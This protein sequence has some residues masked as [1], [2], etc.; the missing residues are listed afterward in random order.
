MRS[1]SSLPE[2]RS[3]VPL[4]GTRCHRS[5]GRVSAERRK[6]DSAALAGSIGTVP[7]PRRFFFFGGEHPS[8]GKI[9]T[10]NPA[11]STAYS[12]GLERTGVYHVVNGNFATHWP[13]IQARAQ[14]K[15]GLGALSYIWNHIGRT[16]GTPSAPNPTLDLNSYAPLGI[17]ENTATDPKEGGTY[18]SAYFGMECSFLADAHGGNLDSTGTDT[19]VNSRLWDPT[20]TLKKGS[21]RGRLLPK[22]EFLGRIGSVEEI[23]TGFVDITLAAGASH[24]ESPGANFTVWIFGIQPAAGVPADPQLTGKFTASAHVTDPG[25]FTI[26]IGGAFTGNAGAIGSGVVCK[27]FFKIL[28]I[29]NPSANLIRLELSQ[30]CD[31]TTC[32][33]IW[34]ADSRGAI[35]LGDVATTAT[36][37]LGRKTV[38]EHSLTFVP[39]IATSTNVSFDEPS[40]TITL[41]TGSWSRTPAAGEKLRVTGS[42]SNNKTVTVVSATASTI[43]C[44][45]DITTEGAGSTVTIHSLHLLEYDHGSA[46]T[47]GGYGGEGFAMIRPHY[48]PVFHA[49]CGGT[50]LHQES[51]TLATAVVANSVAALSALGAGFAGD[52]VGTSD[53]ALVFSI[54]YN[55]SDATGDR[56]TAI[57]NSWSQMLFETLS[58][59]RTDV[60]AAMSTAGLAADALVL[61][62]LPPVWDVAAY[63]YGAI[64]S[65]TETLGTTQAAIISNTRVATQ[66]LTR[67]KLVEWGDL[68][69][70]DAGG[71]T[72]SA[73]TEI[74]TGHRL[75]DSLVSVVSAAPTATES[76]GLPIY[77]LTGQSQTAGNVP[78]LTTLPQPAY[79]S[80]D[81]DYD[82][83]WYDAT[84]TS[85]VRE[86][87]CLIWNELTGTPEEYAPVKNAVTFPARTITNH[88]EIISIISTGPPLGGGVGP[89]ITLVLELRKRHPEG[90]LLVKFAVPSAAL[91]PVEVEGDSLPTFDPAVGDLSADLLGIR[92]RVFAW[93]Y[94]NGRVPDVKAFFFDQGESDSFVGYSSTYQ[95]ALTNFVGWVRENFQTTASRRAA[96]PFV[97]GRVQS[98]AR[99]NS[100][101]LPQ[102]QAV[103]AAQDAVA[104]SMTNVAIAS[105]QDLPIGSDNI[106]RTYHALLIAGQRLNDALDS[107]TLLQDGYEDG[108]GVSINPEIPHGAAASSG[109]SLGAEASGVVAGASASSTSTADLIS[110][111]D[112][113][114]A[115]FLNNGAIQS[116][117]IN[118]RSVSRAS[119]NDLISLRNTLKSD[120]SASL[121]GATTYFRRGTV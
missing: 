74:E 59:L 109:Q 86:R 50:H 120:Y 84:Y 13:T 49:D 11:T 58:E 70:G 60:T 27:P 14:A 96:L 67:A 7:T 23:T 61:L 43:V 15:S 5:E 80:G 56:Q 78:A 54:G 105:M 57:I 95:A 44:S 97:I 104:A 89:E 9:P 71:T 41:G 108:D 46:V 20:F 8:G 75:W 102:V 92:D 18:P 119:L 39:V 6:L 40:K 99:T 100:T 17:S 112:A 94:N 26:A 21:F 34:D 118:G 77:F 115:T 24:G 45:E 87:G 30:P 82:G 35:W 90:F 19:T 48:H 110:Q 33:Y 28:G 62:V 93:A 12:Y 121:G 114:I 106:H 68:E 10:G 53:S 85:V 38:A 1:A 69:A 37:V 65:Y 36:P 72:Y 76:I 103:Q 98:H 101:A 111:L 52:T 32:S 31:D 3:E 116:Y 4:A 79:S 88:P 2:L 63:A 47:V 73:A 64:G 117:S 66:R 16:G 22:Q 83:S 81:P 107:T 51:V 42:S 113:A 91:Q 25:R 55:D 29:T